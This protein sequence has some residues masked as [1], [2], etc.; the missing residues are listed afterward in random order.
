MAREDIPLDFRP[1]NLV[2]RENKGKE[3]KGRKGEK[4]K[5]ERERGFIFSLE[6]PDD[7]TDGFRQSKRK[8]PSSRQ[9]LQ[10]ET[11]NGEFR[12]T[13]RSSSSP[14][15]VIFYPKGCVAVSFPKG[16]VWLQFEL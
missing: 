5:V 13:S 10:V 14:T 8:S 7:R 16:D 9:E 11:G 3:R 15:L 6:F 2:G 12:Q 1:N 4:K